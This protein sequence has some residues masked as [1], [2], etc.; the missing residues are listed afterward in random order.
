MPLRSRPRFYSVSAAFYHSSR[1]AGILASD[2]RAFGSGPE[3]YLS[4]NTGYSRGR[5]I[6]S[7]CLFW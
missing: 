7:W 6:G 3:G 2:P 4:Q 5:A 1:V